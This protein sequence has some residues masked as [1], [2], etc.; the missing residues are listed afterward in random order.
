ME[1]AKMCLNRIRQYRDQYLTRGLKGNQ[2]KLLPFS[3]TCSNIKIKDTLSKMQKKFKEQRNYIR[4]LK[5]I[6]NRKANQ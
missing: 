5:R 6:Q 1:N 3:I 2:N 4:K